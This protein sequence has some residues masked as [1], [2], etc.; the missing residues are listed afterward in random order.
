MYLSYRWYSIKSYEIL[1]YLAQIEIKHDK[2][3]RM[4]VNQKNSENRWQIY[5]IQ[6]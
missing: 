5:E 2:S 6:V 1:I 3:T 4:Y